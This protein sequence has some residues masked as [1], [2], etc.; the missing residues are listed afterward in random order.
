[1]VRQVK[2][3]NYVYTLVTVPVVGHRWFCKWYD[4]FRHKNDD[5]QWRCHRLFLLSSW[6]FQHIFHQLEQWRWYQENLHLQLRP[7]QHLVLK[8][9]A[10]LQKVTKYFQLFVYNFDIFKC[11]KK[12][13]NYKLKPINYHELRQV[14]IFVALKSKLFS[15]LMFPQLNWYFTLSKVQ[16]NNFEKLSLI[17]EVQNIYFVNS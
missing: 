8:I 11:W 17:A 16:V 1:M 14:P 13:L 12:V 2:P 10:N 15:D 3:K 5:T 7:L 6:L 9:L 4:T